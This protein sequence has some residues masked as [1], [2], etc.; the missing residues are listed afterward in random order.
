MLQSMKP[1]HCS[2]VNQKV[3][4]TGSELGGNKLVLWPKGD[5]SS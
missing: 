1:E 2:T 5:E 4:L 3:K